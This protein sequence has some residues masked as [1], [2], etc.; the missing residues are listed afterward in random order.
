MWRIWKILYRV[1]QICTIWCYKC[2][3]KIQRLVPFFFFLSLQVIVSRCAIYFIYRCKFSSR[4]RCSV[5]IREKIDPW[6]IFRQNYFYK[7]QWWFYDYRCFSRIALSSLIL[8]EIIF[9]SR[10]RFDIYY[11]ALSMFIVHVRFCVDFRVAT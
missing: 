9:H 11:F 5:F 10:V 3:E 6:K 2:L 1:F 4:E 8:N 7:T